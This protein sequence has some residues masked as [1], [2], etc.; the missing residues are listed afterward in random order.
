MPARIVSLYVAVVAFLG[1]KSNKPTQ[2][3]LDRMIVDSVNKSHDSWVAR[4]W[5][6]KFR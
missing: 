5:S 1:L 3:Q 6:Q 2:D 4:G